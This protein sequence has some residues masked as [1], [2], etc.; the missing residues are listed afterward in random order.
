MSDC[1][2]RLNHYLGYTD[3]TVAEIASG[4]GY[5]YQS[6][7]SRFFKK[8]AGITPSVLQFNY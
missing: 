1:L 6:Y 2:Q 7:F 5:E 8:Y 4:L 3:Y